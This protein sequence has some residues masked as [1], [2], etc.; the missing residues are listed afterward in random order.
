VVFFNH[1]HRLCTWEIGTS[2]GSYK[3]HFFL[4]KDWVSNEALAL[5]VLSEGGTILYPKNEEVAMIKNG[6]KF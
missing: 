4:P 1:Q 5:V 2:L 3:R 6:I